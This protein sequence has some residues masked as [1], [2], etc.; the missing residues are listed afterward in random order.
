[1]A[2]QFNIS[3]MI[4]PIERARESNFPFARNLIK[5]N[6]FF[7]DASDFGL[8]NQVSLA[9]VARH[10][11]PE[12]FA[13]FQKK[14][15]GQ[16]AIK[17]AAFVRLTAYQRQISQMEN[18]NFILQSDSF[19]EKIRLFRIMSQGL[20]ETI[21]GNAKTID[22]TYIRNLRPPL[23]SSSTELADTVIGLNKK[24][25]AKSA[26]DIEDISTVVVELTSPAEVPK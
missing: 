13:M 17:Q 21:E 11:K 16:D 2:T 4:P 23:N 19:A 1:M 3:E 26:F 6:S 5:T 7:T 10:T 12:E 9:I 15:T 20:S 8:A 18:L 25:L 14:I 22:E 24:V